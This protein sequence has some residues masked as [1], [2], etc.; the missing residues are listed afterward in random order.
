VHR[1]AIHPALQ[2]ED[3]MK[4]SPARAGP[5]FDP[6]VHS[7][8]GNVDVSLSTFGWPHEPRVLQTTKDLPDEFPFRLDYDGGDTIGIGAVSFR[9]S[10]A[11]RW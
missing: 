2:N 11:V 6:A 3:F 4:P 7:H 8:S 1:I 10:G 9:I 5:R